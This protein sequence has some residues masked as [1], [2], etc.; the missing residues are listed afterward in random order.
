MS[1]SRGPRTLAEFDRW[2]EIGR[3]ERLLMSAGETPR[4]A[5]IL[6]QIA[7]RR[8]AQPLRILDAG[9][10]NGRLAEWLPAA[11]RARYLGVDF[12]RAAIE[13]ARARAPEAKFMVADLDTWRPLVPCDVI[14]F[15]E[16]TYYLRAPART[17]AIFARAL[18]PHGCLIVSVFRPVAQNQHWKRIEAP[19]SVASEAVVTNE[20]ALVWDVKTLLPRAPA[21]AP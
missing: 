4:Y 10:G 5:E 19:F 11:E 9:C 6:R 17:M 20:K 18:A 3:G 15:N 16:V 12:S 21:S 2:Y 8:A 1:T 7:A 14:V 13:E